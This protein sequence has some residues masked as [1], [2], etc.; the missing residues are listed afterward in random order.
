MQK[1]KKL[2]IEVVHSLFLPILMNVPVAM[3]FTVRLA[4]RLFPQD[5]AHFGTKMNGPSS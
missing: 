2:I 3:D 1:N 4:N 5:T